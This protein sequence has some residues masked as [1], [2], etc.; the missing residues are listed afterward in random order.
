MKRRGQLSLLGRTLRKEAETADTNKLE[1]KKA[2][3]CVWGLRS[4]ACGSGELYPIQK[5]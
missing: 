3:L 1:Q 5:V 2:A 4:L